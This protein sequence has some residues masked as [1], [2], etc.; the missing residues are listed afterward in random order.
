MK[1]LFYFGL[2]GFILFEIANVYFLMPMRGGSQEINSIDVAYF[3]HVWRWMF[4]AFFI[5][6]MI[7]GV[8]SV[9]RNRK[10]LPVVT[11]LILSA[12][13]YMTNFDMAADTMFHQP[14]SLS[15]KNVSE[16]KVE[17][18]KLIIG[19]THGGEAKAYPIQYLG[20]HHQVRDSI[21][22][23][24]VMV[25]YCTVCRTGRVFEPLVGGKTEDFRLVGMDH[26]N[27]MFEDK[28]TKSWWR[29]ATG[30][31]IAGSLKGQT[32]PEFPCIQTTLNKWTELYPHTLVM[33]PD[34]H[35]QVGYDSMRTYEKGRLTGRLTRRDTASWQNKSWVVGVQMGKTSKTY[36]WNMLQ[37]E[38]IIYDVLDNTPIAVILSKDSSSFVVLE[39]LSIQQTFILANDTLKSGD[40]S[41]NFI[42]K[43]LN[44]SGQDLKRVNAFQEYWHSWFTFHPST[45]KYQMKED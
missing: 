25:T 30:E 15:L 24:P 27:A 2:I 39:R 38:H 17:G 18:D 31:A 5:L 34:T 33:Q 29:Q 3:L 8:K 11:L 19:I 10:W 43:S 20:Y 44:I 12:I 28:T 14:K 23:K 9:F 22:G 4:R 21:G 41:Y 37:K 7:L 26:Y 42:G 36:D 32:L 35:F 45:L 1:K 13:V 16:N 40:N 6:L